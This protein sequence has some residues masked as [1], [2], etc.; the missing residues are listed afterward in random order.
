MLLNILHWLIFQCVCEREGERA[1]VR[2]CVS[3]CVCGA[4]FKMSLSCYGYGVV[5][6]LHLLALC[7]RTLLSVLRA[8]NDSILF[9]LISLFYC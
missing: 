3:E 7:Y 9:L 6:S 5:A 4:F 8:I 1:C 2:V